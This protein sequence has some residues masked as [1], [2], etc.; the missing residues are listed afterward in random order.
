MVLLD[1]EPTGVF[2][3]IEYLDDPG[4]I[5][6][7]APQL[8]E[9]GMHPAEG[10]RRARIRKL[11]RSHVL[12]VD[13]CHGAGPSLENGNRI[14]EGQNEMSRIEAEPPRVPVDVLEVFQ[15]DLPAHVVADDVV[16]VI[17]RHT[18]ADTHGGAHRFVGATDV[19]SLF[20]S[21]PT[22]LTGH[23]AGDH[24]VA[25]PLFDPPRERLR[26]LNRPGDGCGI[27][28]VVGAHEDR[29]GQPNGMLA[30]HRVHFGRLIDLVQPEGR[31]STPS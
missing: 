12:A 19:A 18:S 8:R 9:V 27:A 31:S 4:K 30:E 17:E 23:G 7:A 25:A 14:L 3:F 20:F 10:L 5:D 1:G 15:E 26:L 13:P 29:R 11:G 28:V 6:N 16:V 22:V 2:C 21:A 24:V